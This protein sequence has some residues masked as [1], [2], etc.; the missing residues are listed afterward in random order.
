MDDLLS[1]S[2]SSSSPSSFYPLSLLP[3]FLL[4]LFLPL[5]FFFFFFVHFMHSVCLYHLLRG[6]E[7][8]QGALSEAGAPIFAGCFLNG[9]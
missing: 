4:L 8:F 5:F 3:F 9:A 1:S 7:H 6:Y 2:S